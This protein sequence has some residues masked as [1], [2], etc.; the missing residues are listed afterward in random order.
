MD[1]VA[2][3]AVGIVPIQRQEKMM[4]SLFLAAWLAA[5][6]YSVKSNM[7]PGQVRRR[8]HQIVQ[9]LRRQDPKVLRSV[10]YY[11]KWV[12]KLEMTRQNCKKKNIIKT[13]DDPVL[14][15]LINEA[16]IKRKRR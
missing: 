8:A 4:T 12:P 5:P 1:T 6:S 11:M 10:M 16:G 7:S 3:P 9:L 15:M 14:D 13:H 2:T